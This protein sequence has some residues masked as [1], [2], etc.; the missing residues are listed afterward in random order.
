MFFISK[1]KFRE[2]VEREIA[3]KM[4]EREFRM[5]L[6]MDF[7]RLHERISRL[8]DRVARMEGKKDCTPDLP[9]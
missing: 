6:N 7:S 2:C 3:E 9:Y 5:N 4:D 1:K 8:E